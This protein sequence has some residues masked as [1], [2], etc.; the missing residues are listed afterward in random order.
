MKLRKQMKNCA[1]CNKRFIGQQLKLYCSGPCAS[2]ASY[3]RVKIRE[4]VASIRIDP[5]KIQPL[6]DASF[7]LLMRT[8][9]ADSQALRTKAIEAIEEGD[10]G[11]VQ[12][13]LEMVEIL[14]NYKN[15]L[16]TGGFKK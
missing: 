9:G 2:K 12:A 15:R 8:F 7:E 5:S 16:A 6:P 3:K 11:K 10:H 4:A 1:E 13:Y 14:C